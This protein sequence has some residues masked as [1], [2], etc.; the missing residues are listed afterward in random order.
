MW[1]LLKVT[2]ELKQKSINTNK[3]KT[4]RKIANKHT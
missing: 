2:I 3:I 1:M 4:K